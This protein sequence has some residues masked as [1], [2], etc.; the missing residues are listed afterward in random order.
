LRNQ[1]QRSLR[2]SS[3][4][5]TTGHIRIGREP[6]FFLIVMTI[7]VVSFW[8]TSSNAETFS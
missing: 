7:F 8:C 1:A 6:K 2:Y 3:A 5:E 4:I